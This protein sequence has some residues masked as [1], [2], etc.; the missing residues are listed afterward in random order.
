MRFRRATPADRAA[1]IRHVRERLARY[2]AEGDVPAIILNFD[3]EILARLERGDAFVVPDRCDEPK[4][5]RP[6][7]HM[8][9]HRNDQWEIVKPEKEERP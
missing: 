1:A 4:C 2:E 8:G 5:T 3:R 9:P 7:G 6:H